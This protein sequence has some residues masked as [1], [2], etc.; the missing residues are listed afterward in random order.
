VADKHDDLAT[1]FVALN[2]DQVAKGVDQ[3]VGQLRRN[4]QLFRLVMHSFSPF[5]FDLAKQMPFAAPET[6]QSHAHYASAIL[7]KTCTL[8][9]TLSCR[10][11]WRFGAR[12]HT[13]FT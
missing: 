2:G 6:S 1:Q 10:I 12:M 4:V 5:R 13:Q 7:R 3:V 11:V 9:E 8:L